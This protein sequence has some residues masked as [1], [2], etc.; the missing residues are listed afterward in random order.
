MIR[1]D[2]LEQLKKLRESGFDDDVMVLFKGGEEHDGTGDKEAGPEEATP[3]E[4][5]TEKANI[6]FDYDKVIEE[7][8]KRLIPFIQKE[9]RE[10]GS[11]QKN[12]DDDINSIMKKFAEM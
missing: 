6:Q 9:N 1:V 10:S 12:E 11:G 3:E 4:A 2:S 7:L 5:A 8:E